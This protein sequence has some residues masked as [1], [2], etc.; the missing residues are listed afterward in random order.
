MRRKK[1][2][3]LLPMTR[4]RMHELFRD[5]SLDPDIFADM[6]LYEQKKNYV[7]DPEKVDALFDYVYDPEKVDALFDRRNAEEG[8]IAFAIMLDGAVI[9]EVGLRHFNEED[10]ECE[11]SIHLQNDRVKGLGYGT[12]AERL[13]VDYAFDVLGAESI[14]AESLEKNTRSQHVLE[15]L[16][17]LHQGEED[18]FKRYRLERSSSG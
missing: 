15:K 11:L 1:D 14:V 6:S 17:F 16:G 9:G 10:K 4:E 18:G 8:S 13:A 5:F 12:Q 2:V 7:Y 3:E